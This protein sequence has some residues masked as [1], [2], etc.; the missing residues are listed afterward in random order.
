MTQQQVH[1][2]TIKNKDMTEK[3]YFKAIIKIQDEELAQG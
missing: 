2:E 3:L 1:L